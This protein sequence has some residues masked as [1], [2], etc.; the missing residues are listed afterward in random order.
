MFTLEIKTN[1]IDKIIKNLEHLE[2]D[3]FTDDDLL[4]LA[5]RVHTNILTRTADGKDADGMPFSPYSPS[6]AKIRKEKGRPTEKVDLFFS[7][8]ML[9][10][11]TSKIQKK[12]TALLFFADAQQAAKAHG[13]IS[14][15]NG[16]SDIKR[17]FF[18]L[19]KDDE[20]DLGKWVEEILGRK[21]KKEGF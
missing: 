14:G 16:K 1:G 6:W 20:N 3:L 11:I 7:G 12:G 9:G 21:L 15:W 10:A 2:A 4:E 17:K 18:A 13:H 19:G 5:Q 8:H